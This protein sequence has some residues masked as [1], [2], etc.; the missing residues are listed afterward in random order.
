[1]LFS[2]FQYSTEILASM[3]KQEKKLNKSHVVWKGRNKIVVIFRKHD[4]YIKNFKSS[5]Q[6]SLELIKE[7][8]ITGYKLN[9]CKV[10]TILYINS[11]RGD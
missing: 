11:K 3:L 6:K 4:C 8:V 5:S 9:T 10:I 1:M 2:I 7:L